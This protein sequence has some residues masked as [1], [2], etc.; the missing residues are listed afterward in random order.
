VAVSCMEFECCQALPDDI[1]SIR[2]LNAVII[3]SFDAV[4]C[5]KI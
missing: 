1:I 5:W 3:F 4:Y 2:F